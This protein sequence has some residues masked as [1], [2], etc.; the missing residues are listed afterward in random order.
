[1]AKLI[2][3]CSRSGEKLPFDSTFIRSVLNKITPDNLIPRSPYVCEDNG[4][5]A[6][7]LNPTDQPFAINASVAIGTFL[8]NYPNWYVPG[9][10]SID[11]NYAVVRSDRTRVEA[12]TD[13]F[14]TYSLWAAYTPSLFVVSS[15]QRAI[16][17]LLGSFRPN[18]DAVPW[19]LSSGT[20]GPGFGWDKRLNLIKGNT[21]LVLD[22]RSWALSTSTDRRVAPPKR[23]EVTIG[24]RELGAA[25]SRACSRIR[26]DP[27]R[28]ALAL[29]G[30]YDSRALLMALKDEASLKTITWG[31]PDALT[32]AQSDA[33]IAQTLAG[34]LGIS[35]DFCALRSE[36]DAAGTVF[37]RFLVAGEGRVDHISGYMDGFQTWAEIFKSGVHSLIRGDEAFGCKAVKNDR[38]VL[39]NM[40]LLVLA[41]YADASALHSFR[42]SRLQSRPKSLHR[43]NDESREAWRDRLNREFEIPIVFAAL[44]DLKLCYTDIVNPFLTQEVLN[45]TRLL[46]DDQRTD[47]AEFRS[48]VHGIGI[49]VPFARR[50]AIDFREH[51]VRQANFFSMIVERLD[52]F[53]RD[54]GVPGRLAMLAL[55]YVRRNG[56]E[57]SRDSIRSMLLTIGRISRVPCLRGERLD[58]FV[59]AFR[60]L[61]VCSMFRTLHA[62]SLTRNSMVA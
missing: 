25:I 16:I 26:I 30:G 54:R 50:R 14:A 13:A 11:G 43:R 56:P 44:N 19:V 38:D 5:V 45:V 20:L 42:E 7:I 36:S 21:R 23:H 3:A 28:S 22:R 6:A 29:S 55:D 40:G 9:S 24:T 60:I 39:R 8:G 58:P 31:L 62:E 59:L 48:L 35:H 41:D 1:M 33:A 57:K 2:Y 15:S 53:S 37:D 46:A 34:S 4:S 10:E 12:V 52:D 61:I 51:V 17:A 47:K 49:D 27:D 32:D 18:F